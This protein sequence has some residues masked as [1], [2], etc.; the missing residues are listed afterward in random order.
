MS[1]RIRIFTSLSLVLVGLLLFSSVAA[2]AGGGRGNVPLERARQ[3]LEE[4]LMGVPGIAGIAHSE[5]SGE[6]VV[7]LENEKARGKSPVWFEGYT[8][9]RVVVGTIRALSAPVAEPVAPETLDAI[10]PLRR[11]AVTPLVGGVSL[12]A[13]VEGQ[14]WAGTL[15]MVTY[16]NK[17]LSNAHVIA[18]DLNNNWLASGT[19]VIQPGTLDGGTTYDQVG[20][21]EKYIPI[22]FKGKA[23]NYADAAIA[24]ISPGIAVDSGRQFS[25]SDDYWISG[26][27][28]VNPGDTVRKSGRTSGITLN[29]VY[30]TNASVNVDYGGGHTAY[31]VDQIIVWEPFIDPG[32]SGSAVDKNGSFVGLAFASSDLYGIVCKASHIID[33]LGIALE[34]TTP[35]ELVGIDVSPATASIAVSDT[36]QFTATGTYSDSTTADLTGDATWSSSDDGVAT[37]SPSGL[38]TGVSAGPAT[39]SASTGSISGS[40]SLTVTEALPELTV[41]VKTDKASYGIGDT[42]EITATVTAGGSA[43]SGASVL[44]EVTTGKGKVRFSATDTTNE[45]GEATFQYTISRRDGTG[46]YTVNAEASADGDSDSDSAPFNVSK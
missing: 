43:V 10:S 39:I 35:P 1:K 19:P 30:L 28:T 13:H 34:P 2:A 40:A 23:R 5:E 14:Y 29:E 25:E 36:Q 21:L 18:L 20:M 16:D 32:D 27:T 42:V 31:F 24:S 44:V 33:G 46:T 8:V 45:S 4:R 41:Q 11:A 37:V 6:I 15:G 26:T 9:R 7:L 22:K 12:S 3:V 38:A 17:L